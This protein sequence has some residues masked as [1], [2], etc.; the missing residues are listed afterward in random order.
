[1]TYFTDLT[2]IADIHVAR[3]QLVFPDVQKI[4]PFTQ[5]KIEHLSTQEIL[6][7]DMLTN[8]FSKLQDYLGAK[9]INSFLD[10]T[11]DNRPNAT[12]I[13][14]IN[15]LER[16]GVIES[17]ELWKDFRDTRNAIAHEY[18]GEASITASNLNHLI[19]LVPKLISFY[20]EL[21]KRGV[22]YLG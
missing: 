15:Q 6:I 17:V 21:K 16:L 4:S 10:L 9:V 20:E 8:R 7:L 1:M 11:G 12:M 19:V 13:D 5:E 18:P 22:A 14:K 3:I 2:A